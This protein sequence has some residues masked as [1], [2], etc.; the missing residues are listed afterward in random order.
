MLATLYAIT[1]NLPAVLRFVMVEVKGDP[2][3]MPLSNRA[4]HYKVIVGRK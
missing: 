2:A 1:G 4:V 3:D